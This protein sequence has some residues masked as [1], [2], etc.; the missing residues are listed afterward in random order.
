MRYKKGKTQQ[1]VHE[2]LLALGNPIH[3]KLGF[4]WDYPNLLV[5]YSVMS[6]SVY[7]S[8]SIYSVRGESIILYPP[9]LIKNGFQVD[10]KTLDSVFT[11]IHR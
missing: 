9:P 3:S 7:V 1:D 4:Q 8:S 11:K 6:N 5:E 2:L 10:F